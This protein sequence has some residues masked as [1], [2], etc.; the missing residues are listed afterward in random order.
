[1]V[2]ILVLVEFNLTFQHFAINYL[3]YNSNP[4]ISHNKTLNTLLAHYI[5]KFATRKNTTA[6]MKLLVFTCTLQNLIN[7]CFIIIVFSRIYHARYTRFCK[8]WRRPR[9]I[10]ECAVY[11]NYCTRTVSCQYL[12]TKHHC[13]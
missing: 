11:K 2:I 12:N 10:F 6:I 8:P 7:S 9:G 1:M 4:I 13:K 5:Y 3:N